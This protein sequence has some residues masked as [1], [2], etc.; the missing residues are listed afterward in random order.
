MMAEGKELLRAV[1]DY[2]A[3]DRIER[4][5]GVLDRPALDLREEARRTLA[6]HGGVA[7]AAAFVAWDAAGRIAPDPRRRGKG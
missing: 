6:A 5:D 3:L 1:A 7:V 2:V 4:A